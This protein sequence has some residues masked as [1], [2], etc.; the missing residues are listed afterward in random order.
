MEALTFI[1]FL[2]IAIWIFN[3][4]MDTELGAKGAA[5]FFLALINI[6]LIG[7]II[8]IGVIILIFS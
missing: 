5:G 2:L 8:L 4:V 3:K 6:P 1:F 7:W